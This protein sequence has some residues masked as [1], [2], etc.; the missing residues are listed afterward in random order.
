MRHGYGWGGLAAL[1]GAVLG[2][3]C[4]W[5]MLG[6]ITNDPHIWM[7][8]GLVSGGLVGFLVAGPPGRALIVSFTVI[9]SVL[10]AIVGGFLGQDEELGAV[11]WVWGGGLVGLAVGF[12]AG[13]AVV[14]WAN[15]LLT[16]VRP[17]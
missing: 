14:R 2:A 11:L 3:A 8:L 15:K 7:V 9:G 16:E 12:L 5:Y 6:P 4:G 1:I 13:A 17:R 10:G